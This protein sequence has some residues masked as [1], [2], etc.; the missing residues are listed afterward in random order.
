ML[1][2]RQPNALAQMLT[3]KILWGSFLFVPVTLYV[4]LNSAPPMAGIEMDLQSSKD[5]MKIILSGMAVFAGVLSLILP[6][7]VFKAAVLRHKEASDLNM[8]KLI[9][10]KLPT[11]ILGSA[12]AESVCIF[13]FVLAKMFNQAALFPA[14]AGA[15]VLLIL[16]QFPSENR[17]RS[18]AQNIL[19]AHR[20]IP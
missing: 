5:S 7:L 4:L 20:N 13:G 18:E 6:R 11:L 17:I 2:P 1:Q 9:G 8:L 15:S 10:L 3:M 19:G 14:F 12:L 16:A